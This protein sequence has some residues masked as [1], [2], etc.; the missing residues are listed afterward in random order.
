MSVCSTLKE[1]KKSQHPT[2]HSPDSQVESL[3]VQLVLFHYG[4]HP[5]NEDCAHPRLYIRLLCHVARPWA[6]TNLHKKAHCQGRSWEYR[7]F[8]ECMI[9][10]AFANPLCCTHHFHARR[11]WPKRCKLTGLM[12]FM[13][14]T[15]TPG[16]EK[17]VVLGKCTRKLRTQALTLLHSVQH[18]FLQISKLQK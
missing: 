8:N 13:V 5:I 11:T 2:V 3:S 17:N 6:Q 7:K 18:F 1:R 15:S 14:C 10:G 4:D 16:P 12:H 9:L